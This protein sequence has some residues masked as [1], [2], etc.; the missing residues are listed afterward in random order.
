MCLHWAIGSL[1]PLDPIFYS[2]DSCGHLSVINPASSS[3]PSHG[4]FAIDV[5]GAFQQRSV[6]FLIA[7]MD[8]NLLFQRRSLT[9]ARH[10]HVR[11]GEDEGFSE[12]WVVFF[13]LWIFF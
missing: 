11:G 8:T 6:T 1:A 12:D 7:C 9:S 2:I 10:Q 13:F 4:S 5:A 3:S